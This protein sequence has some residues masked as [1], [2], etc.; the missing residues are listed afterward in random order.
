M[1]L[2]ANFDAGDPQ[3]SDPIERES[4]RPDF[5][6]GIAT[7]H[8]GKKQS[9]FKFRKDT[10]PVFLVH[11]TNDGINGARRSNCRRGSKPTWKNSASRCT[12]KSSTK[13]PT[14]SAT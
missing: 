6:V 5:A 10:P 9:P 8:W 14:A 2:A 7:W 3:S 12:S 11:A 13:A 1:N 4:S